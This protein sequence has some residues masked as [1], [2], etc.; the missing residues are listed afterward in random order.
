M[1]LATVL[2]NG[3]PT[4]GLLAA[5][6]STVFPLLGFEDTVDFIAEGPEVWAVLAETAADPS[7]HVPVEQILAPISRPPKLICIGLNYRD[8]AIESKMELPK[9][10]VVFTKFTSSIVGPGATVILPKAS[11]QPD[12]EAELAIVIGKGGR[13]IAAEDWQQHVFGYT[14]INDVS[15]RDIQLATSQWSMGKSFDTFC[16]M[17]PAIVTLDELGDPHKLAI[18][19][20]IGG[21]YLQ[22]S[23][24]DE[25]VFK[26]G[27]LLAYLSSIMTLTPGD[28]IS[29]GTPAGVG[30]GRTPKRWLQPGETMTVE[31]EK[32]GKL[33]N[34]IA[35]E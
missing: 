19:L 14:I 17:G 28:I 1:R 27:E 35:A 24:T 2:L 16:P 6:D 11:T 26:T 4:P 15:A 23:N 9:T 34:P 8:H 25:L 13:N 5:N 31:I 29:T 18:K 33:T 32:I 10:P 30:L 12:Y 21:E 7:K 3:T 20:E 22:D